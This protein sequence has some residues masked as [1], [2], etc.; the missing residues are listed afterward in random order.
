MHSLAL[1]CALLFPL[2]SSSR[3]ADS[4]NTGLVELAK[5]PVAVLLFSSVGSGGLGVVFILT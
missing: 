5:G 2:Q 1:I 3:A 4:S